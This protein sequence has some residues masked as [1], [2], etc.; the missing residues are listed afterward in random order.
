MKKIVFILALVSMAAASFGA[1]S[2]KEWRNIGTWEKG[3]SDVAPSGFEFQMS[4]EYMPS[5]G[6]SPTTHF[7]GVP[8]S[9]WIYDENDTFTLTVTGFEDIL[10]GYEGNAYVTMNIDRLQVNI[11]YNGGWS[12]AVYLIPYSGPGTYTCGIADIVELDSADDK[13]VEGMYIDIGGLFY[14]GYYNGKFQLGEATEN[15][16]GSM[17][18]MVP[19]KSEPETVVPD[20]SFPRGGY[21]H[22]SGSTCTRDRSC[23]SAE[24]SSARRK[25]RT[26]EKSSGETRREE[27]ISGTFLNDPARHWDQH[28]VP[29]EFVLF[30]KILHTG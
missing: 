3:M 7:R 28:P 17:Q 25:A 14:N 11:Y 23:T 16:S 22:C 19:D 18:F 13:R 1:V 4:P 8:D 21:L 2:I 5:W 27:K 29:G 15:T 10:T 20:R 12:N 26:G 30:S 6:G 24:P 9:E